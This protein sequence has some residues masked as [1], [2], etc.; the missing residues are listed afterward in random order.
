VCELAVYES[1]KNVRKRWKMVKCF[2]KEREWKCVAETN[3]K[4]VKMSYT[5]ELGKVQDKKRN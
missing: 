2:Q 5:H 4:S 3:L 1:A